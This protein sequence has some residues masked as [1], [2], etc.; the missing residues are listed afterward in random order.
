[1]KE[2]IDFIP[3]SQERARQLVRFVVE[4]GEGGIARAELCGRMYGD[5]GR[6]NRARLRSHLSWV[7]HYLR[8]MDAAFSIVST[9]D[10]KLELTTTPQRDIDMQIYGKMHSTTIALTDRHDQMLDDLARQ[11]GLSR[12]RIVRELVEEQWECSR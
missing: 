12:S 3:L 2:M 5:E 4:A 1:M 10:G 9:G 8:T 7:R 11:L 6:S